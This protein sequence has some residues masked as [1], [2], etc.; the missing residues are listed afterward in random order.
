MKIKLI[1][2]LSFLFVW[3]TLSPLSGQE[4]FNPH[5]C[6]FHADEKD[7]ER[8]LT[9]LEF[10]E[11]FEFYRSSSTY[12]VPV[13]FHLIARADGTGRISDQDAFNQLCIINQNYEPYNIQFF[14]K[15]K[16]FNY[17]NSNAAFNNPINSPSILNVNRDNRAV[18]IYW[19][20]ETIPNSE[21]RTLGYY[22]S[23]WDW[24]VM[25][26]DQVNSN[27][28]LSHEI[29]HFFSLMHTF[30][31]WEPEPWEEG[32]HGNPVM[33]VFAP[34]T[35]T[36]IRVELS[37][38]S[39]CAISAD[40]ICDTPPDYGFGSR[41]SGCAPF[42]IEVR[43]RNNDLVEPMQNN[44]MSY[45]FNCPDYDF[46]PM[47][48]S[49]M[50]ADFLSPSRSHLRTGF[51]TPELGEITEIPQ[52]IYPANNETSDYFDEV[53]LM[54]DEVPEASFYFLEV[55]A[56]PLFGTNMIA[57]TIVYGNEFTLNNLEPN[58]LYYWRVK[59]MNET[60]FC[61]P[62][63][64]RYSFRTSDIRT[65]VTTFPQGQF[66]ISL[67]KNPISVGM[68]SALIIENNLDI[69]E[70]NFEI[71]SING[72]LLSNQHAKLTAGNHKLS[73]NYNFINTGMYMISVTSNQYRAILPLVV[74]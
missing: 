57:E 58:R 4:E 17:I 21:G 12:Y 44:Y 29:G 67:I 26:N 7:I 19:A 49:A 36:Q 31:G 59:P 23:Q 39:N 61:A 38:G 62:R 56:F 2:I 54:W 72:Q 45:F 20:S 1:T 28:I 69:Q 30:F 32:I 65:S 46:T 52:P 6:G 48:A 50:R 22:D 8:L 43:D 51:G 25:R 14:L 34:T 41:W 16:S 73:L 24:I 27:L 63:S 70:L 33:Q 3:T 11:T 68:N 18:N 13:K 40:R 71:Y 47:Q 5:F 42:N 53:R 74:N 64:Q 10:A 66:S 60:Q 15:D 9:N 37:N 55:S 35:W